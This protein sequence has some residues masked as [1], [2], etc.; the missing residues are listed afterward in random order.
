MMSLREHGCGQQTTVFSIIQIGPR[1]N[2]MIQIQTKI[3]LPWKFQGN[4]SGM[5][6]LVH[7]LS[8]LYVKCRK[9]YSVIEERQLCFVYI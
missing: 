7:H 2:Q 6:F 4:G 5:T 9:S 1:T 3:V 8:T